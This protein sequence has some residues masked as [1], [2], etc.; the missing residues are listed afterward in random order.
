MRPLVVGAALVLETTGSDRRW[1]TSGSILFAVA[2]SKITLH[3]V[4]GESL[5]CVRRLRSRGWR[6]R[7]RR[8]R[9]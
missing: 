8:A 3:L 1:L 4:F 2:L 5:L 9:G 6:C 7:K